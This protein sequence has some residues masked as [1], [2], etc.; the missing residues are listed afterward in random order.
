MNIDE[1]SQLIKDNFNYLFEEY[2]FNVVYIHEPR[3]R[4]KVFRVGLQAEFCKILFVREQG[5]G[6]SFLGTSNAP[7]N[8]EMNENWVS[9]IGLLGYILRKDFDWTFLNT[10][11][12]RQRIESSLLFSSN[13]FRPYCGEMIEM[14]SSQENMAKWKPAYKQYIKEKVHHS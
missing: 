7:F 4:H 1:Y 2:G 8:N 13:Q 6:V 3:S 12:H 14:F 9:L 11:P 10:I 5:A